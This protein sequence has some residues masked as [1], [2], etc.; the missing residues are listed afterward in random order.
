MGQMGCMPW[1][2]SEGGS[3]R[4]VS[5]LLSP[6]PEAAWEHVVRPWFEKTVTRG[7]REEQPV[8]VVTASRSQAYFFRSRLLAEGK[9]LLGVK[10]VSAPQARTSASRPRHQGCSAG[11]SSTFHC[12]RGRGGRA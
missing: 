2:P 11:T 6:L 10:F 9:S 1:K 4:R 12:D 8:V 7:L 3:V 5:L